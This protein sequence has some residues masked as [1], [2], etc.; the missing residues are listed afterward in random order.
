[1]PRRGKKGTDDSP[2][3]EGASAV[4]GKERLR[5]RG[6][7]EA[8][9]GPRCLKCQGRGHMS[10]DCPVKKQLRQEKS[11]CWVCGQHGHSRREC[12]GVDGES[13][14]SKNKGKS[15]PPKGDVDGHRAG[16][17]LKEKKGKLKVGEEDEML[18]NV[19]G[20]T[21]SDTMPWIDGYTRLDHVASSPCPRSTS[22]QSAGAELPRDG[23]GSSLFGGAIVQVELRTTALL[24]DSLDALDGVSS[25][26][27]ASCAQGHSAHV[28]ED[29]SVV[30]AFI[31]LAFSPQVFSGSAE[32]CD[33][34]TAVPV[35]QGVLRQHLRH[36]MAFA[37]G[38]CGIDLSGV[39]EEL[40]P[41]VLAS[42]IEWMRTH[43]QVAAQEE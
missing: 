40:V 13:W 41:S 42:Q 23:W 32:A 14:C 28:L 17:L 24:D 1:M 43:I 36:P 21:S 37:V 34:A 3:D 33:A 6:A 8:G 10:R 26:A 12:P 5:S 22:V 9:E 27:A 29:K 15:A 35:L 4:A 25:G 31:G 20:L 11:K 2:D 7:E 19:L 30:G 38:V 39:S 16:A 18:Q